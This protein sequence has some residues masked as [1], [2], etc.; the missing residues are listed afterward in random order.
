MSRALRALAALTILATATTALPFVRSTT[1]P[2]R[3]DLPPC[4][5]WR[6]RQITYV[7]NASAFT[8]A[9]CASS[10][11]AASLVR[12]SFVPWM[13]A[14]RS[15]ASQ[16]CTD[17]S[18]GDC[19][20][21]TR[22]DLGYDENH[23]EDNVNLVVFRKGL[24]SAQSDSICHP[25]NPDDIGPCIEKY[26]CWSHDSAT[27]AGGILALTT[28][29]FDKV[30]GEISDADLELH[31]WNGSTKSPD[32]FYFTCAP[33][34]AQP[35]AQEFAGSNCIKYDVG[36]TVT[37]EAGHMLG[38]D[39]VCVAAY[40]S[41]YNSCGVGDALAADTMAPTASPGA[42]NKRTLEADDVEGVCTIYPAGDSTATCSVT[43]SGQVSTPTVPVSASPLCS[44]FSSGPPPSS[45]STGGCSATGAGGLPLLVLAL[46]L[47]RRAQRTIAP[48]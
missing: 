11:D 29:S 34:G 23:P 9:G 8:G 7:V 5:W 41:P 47:R 38:L 31:G 17:L 48:A 32:G 45:S 27:G 15:G 21:S 19:G 24:C 25:Q 39:H 36:N 43:S 1:T 40:P 44:A 33:P 14:T 30:T 18:F 46:A 2:N 13:K 12:A 3:P 28:T 22:T 35:C 10:A 42:T 6:P 37:H 20:N 4:L 16:P 26:N